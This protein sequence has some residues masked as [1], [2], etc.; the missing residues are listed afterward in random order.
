MLKGR[1][2]ACSLAALRPP[3]LTLPH[4]GGG[5]QRILSAL[6]VLISV[7]AMGC[8]RAKPPAPAANALP[9]AN[10]QPAAASELPDSATGQAQTP[11]QWG[12]LLLTA[13]PTARES[14]S[15]AL[16][17]LGKDGFPYLL[18]GMQSRSWEVRLVSLRAVP[19]E[20][21]MANRSRALPVLADLAADSNPQIAQYATIRLGW[22]G[23]SAQSALPVLKRKLAENAGNHEDTV[24]AIIDI[25]DSVPLLAG[26]LR[27]SNP[28]LRKQAAIRLLGLGKNGTR[29]D[30]AG[31]VLAECAANDDDPEVRAVASAALGVIQ[32][33]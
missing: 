1:D 16:R 32:N 25:H 12:T 28:L 20:Q 10:L 14:A 27:D 15:R 7:L 29:I 24:Q 9:V 11:A 17:D 8:G 13:D 18:Q 33:R 5:N 23:A 31:R 2:S 19:K 6:A 21:V 4:K 3:T 26:L 30:A 22:L